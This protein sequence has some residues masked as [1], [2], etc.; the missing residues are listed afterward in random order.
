[1]ID[2][3]TDVRVVTKHFIKAIYKGDRIMSEITEK[4]L[5]EHFDHAVMTEKY[6]DAMAILHVIEKFQEVAPETSLNN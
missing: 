5:W 4:E 6:T 2:L 3:G 1:V